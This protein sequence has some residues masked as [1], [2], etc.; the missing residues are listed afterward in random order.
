MRELARNGLGGG[1]VGDRVL[2]VA[3]T[4]R[5]D[6]D[7][8]PDG[9]DASALHARQVAL[10]GVPWTMVDEVHGTAVIAVDDDAPWVPMAGVGD[11]VVVTAPTRPV[12]VWTA[13]CAPLILG[14]RSGAL[15]AGVHAGWKGLA[16]GVIDAAVAAFHRSGTAVAHAVLGPTIRGCCYEFGAA[17]LAAVASGVGCTTAELTATTAAGTRGLDM[18]HAVGAALARHGIAVDTDV[19]CTGCDP[20]WFSHRT[21]ADAGRHATVAWIE[22][23]A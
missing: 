1:S 19:P 10:T 9:P 20:R 18:A 6:G 13:D 22:P 11:V 15:V 12:A 23:N 4:E 2:V 21:R 3:A 14:D 7:L 8:R 16:A 5:A 17:D